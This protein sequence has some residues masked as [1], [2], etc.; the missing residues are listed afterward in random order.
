M[1][2]IVYLVDLLELASDPP[3]SIIM[4]PPSPRDG[5]SSS[6]SKR[7]SRFDMSGAYDPFRPIRQRY[8]PVTVLFTQF[9]VLAG[10]ELRNFKRDWTLVVR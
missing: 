10:R 1:I 4:A 8:R 5:D 9:E 3:P 7:Q 6:D 2:L